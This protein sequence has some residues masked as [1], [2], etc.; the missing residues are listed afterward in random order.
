MAVGVG[1]AMVVGMAVALG[2]CN[3]WEM[4]YYNIT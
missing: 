2:R 3:H 4:L 1:V